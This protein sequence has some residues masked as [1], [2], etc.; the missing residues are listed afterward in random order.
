[1]NPL[2]DLVGQY[3][4]LQHQVI[5][6]LVRVMESGQ[7][8]LGEEVALFEEEFARYCG[9]THCIGVASGTDALR[10]TLGALQI[11]PGDEVITV[12]NTFIAT[13][14]AIS[15]VGATPVFVDVREEDFNIDVDLIE[16]AVTERT[17]AIIPV[18]LYGQPANMGAVMRI[19]RKHGLKVIEDAC[20]AHGAWLG[21]RRVG[22]F[23][24]VA[25]FSF[26]PG[27]NLG[28]YGDGGAIV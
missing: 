4:D 15:H 2:V 13:A 5:P 11:G 12:A 9:T 10:L 18:H 26:Y 25:C 8:I 22:S 14:L 3:R 7:F 23:G 24:D 6:A 28:A 16:A 21:D 20:Q 1:M 19:A 17:R 27:K